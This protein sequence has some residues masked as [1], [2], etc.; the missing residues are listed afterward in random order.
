MLPWGGWP[1]DRV[2]HC[3][4][5]SRRPNGVSKLYG[6][7]G[8][9]TACRNGEGRLSEEAGGNNLEMVGELFNEALTVMVTR[10]TVPFIFKCYVTNC[11]SF[12]GPIDSTNMPPSL[13]PDYRATRINPQC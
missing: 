7:S 9:I 11:P 8:E 6:F 12:F 2:T 3:L 4:S 1:Q 13:P 10:S 5:A